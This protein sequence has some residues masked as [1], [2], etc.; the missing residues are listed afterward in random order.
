MN[1]KANIGLGLAALGRPGYINIGHAEDLE[2][3]FAI[4]AM[5]NRAHG[6]L[7]AA[8]ESGIRYFDAARSYGRAE[9]FLGSWIRARGFA[10]HEIQVGSKWGYTYTAAWQ[11]ETPDGVQ[12]EIKRHEISVLQSQYAASFSNLGTHLDL[13]QIHSATLES[14]VLENDEVLQLLN[15]LRQTGIRIGVSVSGP[16][17]PA[18]I[19]KALSIEI[20]GIP[21]FNSIQATWNLLEKSAENPLAEASA[22]GVQ[23]IV[24][25]SLANGRLTAR[26]ESP[27]FDSRLRLLE[28]VAE[29]HN[30]TIDAL[31]L[32]AAINQPWATTVLSGAVTI[33]HL[34]SNLNARNLD[35][36]DSISAELNS[37]G[38]SPSQYWSTRAQLPWN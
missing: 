36:N 26:N 6:V 35:W 16:Q 21:L 15:K 5:R 30:T 2:Q 27:E 8:W 37:I 11:V 24:K 28:R 18:A 13:Y 9:E 29:E 31:A 10:P 22:R 4:N 7:D 33:E 1:P 14:G 32:A 3:K 23:V 19:E 34:R 25:E 17:Q 20:D 38:E 12:H